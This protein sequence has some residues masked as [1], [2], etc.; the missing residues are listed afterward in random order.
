[1][2][3]KLYQSY[4]T[5]IIIF[6]RLNF[7]RLSHFRTIVFVPWKRKPWMQFCFLV[8]YFIVY[9]WA[10][11]TCR[12]SPLCMMRACRHKMCMYA[13]DKFWPAQE[14]NWYQIHVGLNLHALCMWV[15]ITLKQFVRKMLNRSGRY[16]I[17]VWTQYII[18]NKIQ[19]ILHSLI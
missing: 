10:N 19:C 2:L 1:M 13:Q 12:S 8:L 14:Y 16:L 3:L 4:Y 9:M 15:N 5:Y 7:N 17:R 6:F 18:Y 11:G